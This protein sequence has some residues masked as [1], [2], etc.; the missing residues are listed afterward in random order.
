VACY[1]P[2]LVRYPRIDASKQPELLPDDAI[3]GRVLP[4][5]AD[6]LGLPSG[7]PVVAGLN[8]TQAGG[9]GA[10]A[11]AGEL[12]E[13]SIGCSSVMIALVRFK[14]TDIR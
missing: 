3:D 8:D 14:R 4:D 10:H 1:D 5:V 13:L 6:E 11:F 9:F 12:A 2:P 7:T